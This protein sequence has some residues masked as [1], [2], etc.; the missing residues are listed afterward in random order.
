MR[1]D[2]QKRNHEYSKPKKEV[3]EKR[4]ICESVKPRQREARF[5]S[6]DDLG[7]VNPAATMKTENQKM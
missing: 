2:E 7:R 3:D 4:V 1:E 5:Y 6:P